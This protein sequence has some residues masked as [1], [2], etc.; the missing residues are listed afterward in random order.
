VTDRVIKVSIG[1]GYDGATHEDEYE[2][3]DDW[4][5]WS[6]NEQSAHLDDLADLSLANHI[7]VSAWVEGGV[8]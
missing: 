8:S 7:D 2:L 4:D 6:K 3:P 5:G 1:T